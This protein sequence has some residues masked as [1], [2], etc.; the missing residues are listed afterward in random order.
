MLC[1]DVM[2]KNPECCLATTPVD[3]VAHTM[4][5][6]EI[7]AMLVVDELNDKKLVG[8]V[9]DRDLALKVVGNGLDPR[10]TPVGH[11]M[12]S[13]PT[14]SCKPQDKVALAI[15]LMEGAHINR[16]AVVDEEEHVLGI[17]SR[18]DII[19]KINNPSRSLQMVESLSYC[20]IPKS[21]FP[22]KDE[23]TAC[24]KE[25]GAAAEKSQKE[26]EALPENDACCGSKDPLH[27]SENFHI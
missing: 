20:H 24:N 27:I 22:D 5:E 23:S 4:A 7:G 11:V 12:S 1:S 3:V 26:S 21:I 18:S 14:V 17:I 25:N 15:D 9:T 13:A 2:T 10:L 8:I 19:S 6:E 16:I